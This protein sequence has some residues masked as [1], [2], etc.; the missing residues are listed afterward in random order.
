MILD[1]EDPERIGELLIAGIKQEQLATVVAL[2]RRKNELDRT[3]AGN[4]QAADRKANRDEDRRSKEEKTSESEDAELAHGWIL[5]HFC[6]APASADHCID[7]RAGDGARTLFC[8]DQ[9]PHLGIERRDRT[10]D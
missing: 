5:G 3:V 6:C 4:E 7:T 8:D 1:L 2:F 10:L 9:L